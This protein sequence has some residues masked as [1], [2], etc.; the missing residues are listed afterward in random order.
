MICQKF[1]QSIIEDRTRLDQVMYDYGHACGRKNTLDFN[2]VKATL[3]EFD[4]EL[5]EI[6]RYMAM[7]IKGFCA[8]L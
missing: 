5:L 2:I 7:I 4:F 3:A 6:D 8:G 1:Y